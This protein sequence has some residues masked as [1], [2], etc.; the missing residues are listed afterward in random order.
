VASL[1]LIC[2]SHPGGGAE[3]CFTLNI[4]A[5]VSPAY[6]Q[7]LP[8]IA[9]K[10]PIA[11]RSSQYVATSAEPVLATRRT[12]LAVRSRVG[13]TG[14]SSRDLVRAATGRADDGLAA[15]GGEK[16]NAEF[17]SIRS[18]MGARPHGRW[19]SSICDEAFLIGRLH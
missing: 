1:Q 14:P 3:A 9:I 10:N 15:L 12:A 13:K 17:A 5:D 6:V 8:A 19:G 7:K 16:A 11:P 18:L 2:A 4:A